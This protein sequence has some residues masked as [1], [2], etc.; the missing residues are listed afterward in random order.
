MNQSIFSRSGIISGSKLGAFFSGLLCCASAFA[1][2][3]P[4]HSQYV[5]NNYLLNPAITGIESYVDVKISHRNQWTGIDGAPVTTS[6][7]IHA[8]LGADDAMQRINPSSYGKSG[9]NVRGERVN[10]DYE[11]PK[12]HHGIGLM[13]MNDRTGYLNRVSVYGTYAYHMPVA[14]KLTLSA[15]FLA[16][17]SNTSLDRSK[18]VW[19]SLNPND[20]AIGY[21]NNELSRFLPEVGAGLWLYSDVFYAGASVLNILPGKA[22]FTNEQTYGVSY[23]PHFF[24]TGG[25]KFWL[26]DDVTALPSVMLQLVQPFSPQIHSN[27]KLQYRDLAW[28]GAGYRISDEL[29]GL[30]A[31]AGFNV[32]NTF[33]I[34]YA[35]DLSTS[36][37]LRTY[38]KNTHEIMIGFLL[39]NRYG[40]LCPRQV[41]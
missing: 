41:W 27:I 39:N 31:M 13:A 9:E 21:N 26:S 40:E 10:A 25:Y 12:A 22:R 1:Q 15:G 37:R 16:G 24:F 14:N 19:G 34:G 3:K 6:F 4:A 29:G 11:T 28:L 32:S 20:P 35:Y 17:F 36:S 30:T 18:I 38:S 8:P 23:T 7:S 5:L 2:Q 33:N